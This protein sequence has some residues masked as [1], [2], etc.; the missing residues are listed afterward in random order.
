MVLGDEV[1]ESPGFIACPQVFGAVMSLC[2]PPVALRAG[3]SGFSS[4]GSASA[5]RKSLSSPHSGSF[6]PVS[7]Q[8]GRFI[9]AAGAESCLSTSHR[10]VWRFRALLLQDLSWLGSQ[11]ECQGG[12]H[13]P[14]LLERAKSCSAAWRMQAA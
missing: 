7:V 6:K 13:Q 5:D 11:W 8:Q 3:T 12:N 14:V 4:L 2:F 9:S 10:M 1:E